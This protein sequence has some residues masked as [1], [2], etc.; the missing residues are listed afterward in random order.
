MTGYLQ[1]SVL[2]ASVLALAGCFT[3]YRCAPDNFKGLKYA[4]GGGEIVEH[5]QIQNYGWYLFD[6][7]P[8]VC[9][10]LNNGHMG[11]MTFFSDQV[12]TDLMTEKFNQHVR[13]TNTKAVSVVT[14][15]TDWVTF[16]VP[17]LAIAV[18]A[19]LPYIICYR[20]VQISS[21]LLKKE[22]EETPDEK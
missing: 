6:K 3:E 17:G 12:R 7:F 20:E 19:I 15:N 21:L 22:K 14:L 11:P 4:E 9:G 8:L 1:K 10:D 2:L 16:E 18:P 5:Y 13:E